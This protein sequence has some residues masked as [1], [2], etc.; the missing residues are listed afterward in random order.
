MIEI[1]AGN[2]AAPYLGIGYGNVAGFGEALYA[3]RDVLPTYRAH[4]EQAMAHAAIAYAKA[5]F[6]RRMMACDDV[7]RLN[8]G[9]VPTFK[10]SWDQPHEGNL[11][12]FLYRRRATPSRLGRLV[13]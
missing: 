2:R 7:D 6:R 13:G 3:H 8:I 5:H 12:E 4:N 10:L 1:K 9:P 11:F